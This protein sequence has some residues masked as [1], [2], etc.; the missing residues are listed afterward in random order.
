MISG[1]SITTAD[2]INRRLQYKTSEV[3]RLY[4]AKFEGG[5][6]Y[7]YE[8]VSDAGLTPKTSVPVTDDGNSPSITVVSDNAYKRQ[9]EMNPN[10]SK[11]PS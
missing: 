8:G 3:R 4:R 1:D 11:Y 2:L 9:Q 10:E 6:D 5:N 7:K